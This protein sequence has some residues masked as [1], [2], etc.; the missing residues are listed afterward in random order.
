MRSLLVAVTVCVILTGS[1][2]A[3][4]RRPTSAASSPYQNIKA[5]DRNPGSPNTR[6]QRPQHRAVRPSAPASR[7]L[8]LAKGEMLALINAERARA[9]AGPLRVDA[10]LNAIAQARS[11]DMIAH[12]YF[13]HHMPGGGM[14]FD[15]L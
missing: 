7:G 3:A 6:G 2:T 9:G 5:I 14:V 12:H 10:T 4:A 11:Q 13:S 15:I 1:T 8:T